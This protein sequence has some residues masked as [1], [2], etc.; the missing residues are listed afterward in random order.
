MTCYCKP[1]IGE[2]KLEI[3]TRVP[4]TDFSGFRTS[5]DQ[6]DENLYCREWAFNY[7]LQQSMVVGTS[8]VVVMINIITCTVF[9]KIV[10]VEKRHTVNDETVGQFV[11][12]TIMQFVNIAIVILLVNFKFLEGPFLGFIPILNGDYKDFTAYWYGQ[13]GKTLTLTLL[14]NIFSPHASKLA[15]PMMQ[16]VKRC[17]DRGCCTRACCCCELK[18]EK[19]EGESRAGELDGTLHDVHTKKLTQYDLNLLYTGAQISSHYVYAQN[20]TYLFCVMMFSAGLPILYPFACIAFF[21][22]YWVYKFLL[23]KFYEKTTRFNEE[24]PMYSITWIKFAI[25]IHGVVGL[26]MYTNS[27]LFPE[28]D[29]YQGRVDALMAYIGKWGQIFR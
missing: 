20:Y 4:E 18:K 2:L 8:V 15:L 28:N 5:T 7:A 23:L 26:L 3:F 17:V 10:F 13:V 14:I 6:P 16:I 25:L 22:L 21:V 11:K 24:L 1:L 12:I 29:P 9:E 19:Q 27:D